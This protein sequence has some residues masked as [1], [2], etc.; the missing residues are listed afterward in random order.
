MIVFYIVGT[1]AAIVLLFWTILVVIASRRSV[2]SFGKPTP[3][4]ARIATENKD[5][6]LKIEAQAEKDRQEVANADKPALLASL[7][8]LVGSVRKK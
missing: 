3:E 8:A 4:E 2:Q 5:I 1:L 6:K 7:R